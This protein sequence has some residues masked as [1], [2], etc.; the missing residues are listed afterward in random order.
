MVWFAHMF[1]FVEDPNVSGFVMVD[2]RGFLLLG[3][4]NRKKYLQLHCV[5]ESKAIFG[6]GKAFGS[7][8][9]TGFHIV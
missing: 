6:S 1:E 4:Q 2:W 3:Y 8:L 5:I 9:K 7:T